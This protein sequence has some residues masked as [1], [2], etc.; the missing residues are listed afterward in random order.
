MGRT[1]LSRSVV[2]KLLLP[3]FRSRLMRPPLFLLRLLRLPW[4]R[5]PAAAA[6]TTTMQMTRKQAGDL[7][8]RLPLPRRGASRRTVTSP[9]AG[10]QF[11]ST[12]FAVCRTEFGAVAVQASGLDRDTALWLSQ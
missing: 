12:R 3:G 10:A 6:A 5:L 9:G 2:L 8:T 4:L 11:L 7:A 1:Y